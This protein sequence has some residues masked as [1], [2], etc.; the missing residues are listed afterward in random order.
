M[1]LVF[2]RSRV[3][4]AGALIFLG[5]SILIHYEAS[6]NPV[7]RA[8]AQH[9]RLGRPIFIFSEFIWKVI[10]VGTFEILA[11]VIFWVS[12]YFVPVGVLPRLLARWRIRRSQQ[13][14]A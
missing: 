11:G 5:L 1:N 12:F 10:A 13:R 14:K 6:F 3:L 7:D 2:P 4:K 8:I 9:F